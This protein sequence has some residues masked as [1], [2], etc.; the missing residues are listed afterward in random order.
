MP[1]TRP[2]VMTI[3]GLDPTGGAGIYADIKTFENL[4]VYGLTVPTANTIQSET[5]FYTPNWLPLE[6]ILKQIKLLLDN[7]PIKYCKIGIVKDIQMLKA[8]TN[9]LHPKRIKIILDP[10]LTSSSGFEFHHNQQ[11]EQFKNIFES[12]YMITPNYNEFTSLFGADNIE[13]TALALSKKTIVYLKGGH[14]TNQIGKDELYINGAQKT[15]RSKVKNISPK[16][17]SGCVLSAALIVYLSK[18]FPLYKAC[19]K[20]KNYMDKYLSSNT[21]LLGW[22]T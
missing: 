8:I 22:H 1:K 16:H 7:Y 15:F 3:A 6:L 17:G 14:R 12:C 2:F 11:L 21:S 18:G 19:I 9:T 5:K 13:H 20:T 4:K 10:I